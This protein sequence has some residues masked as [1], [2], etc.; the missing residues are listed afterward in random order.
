[1]SVDFRSM[2]FAFRGR[3]GE[4]PRRY[5]PAGSPLPR[6]PAGVSR[7]PLQSTECEKSTFSFNTDIQIK[8]IPENFFRDFFMFP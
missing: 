7:I 1:L 3:S 6:N 4:P 5:A 2:R 8:K